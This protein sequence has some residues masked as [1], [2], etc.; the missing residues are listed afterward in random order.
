M[1]EIRRL[2]KSF[3]LLAAVDDVSFAV[4]Q[5]E[6]LGFLGPNGAGKSTTMK[7]IAGFLPPDA[8]TAIVCGHDINREPLAA[9][10]RIGYLP[11]G[12]PAYPDMTAAEFLHFVA[13]IRGFAGAEAK[14]RIDRVI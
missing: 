12:A 6:V 3:G 10:R 2:V 14:R 13:R 8:G 9:K 7:M 5:G 4:P 11:E 1:L